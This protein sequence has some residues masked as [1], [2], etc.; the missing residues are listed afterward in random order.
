MQGTRRSSNTD[1][2]LGYR[3][4][5]LCRSL[6][7]PAAS[8]PLSL[9][10]CMTALGSARRG[11]WPLPSQHQDAFHIHRKITGSLALAILTND[12]HGMLSLHGILSRNSSER[13]YG[14]PIPSG[15]AW[16]SDGQL[17]VEECATHQLKWPLCVLSA[18]TISVCGGFILMPTYP[19][20]SLS[21]V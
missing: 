2:D 9:T 14:S 17:N 19:S 4:H 18:P 21:A 5:V 1:L 15:A 20:P 13:V 3:I 11:V 12:L 10:T 16:I 7:T 8:T 6:A